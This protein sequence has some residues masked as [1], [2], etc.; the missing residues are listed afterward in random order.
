[1]EVEMV[2]GEPDNG[3][4]PAGAEA[5]AVHLIERQ[6]EEVAAG[7]EK[8]ADLLR[9]VP[10]LARGVRRFTRFIVIEAEE[11]REQDQTDWQLV[12]EVA[13]TLEK[14]ELNRE[15]RPS[16]GGRRELVSELSPSV[17]FVVWRD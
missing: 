4:A 12:A 8:L 7:L 16:L 11:V 14:M 3:E 6:A 13:A 9:R 17:E 15:F 1:V 2:N 10:S 5:Q